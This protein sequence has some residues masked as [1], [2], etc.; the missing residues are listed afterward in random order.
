M[1]A[2]SP[3][4]LQRGRPLRV[5]PVC[6]STCV[7]VCVPGPELGASLWLSEPSSWTA[8]ADR[9]EARLLG[10]LNHCNGC[11][12]QKAFILKRLHTSIISPISI[13][14]S[15]LNGEWQD[16]TLVPSHVRLPDRMPCDFI[17]VSL[18]PF[19]ARHRI[20]NH[21]PFI[22]SALEYWPEQCLTMAVNPFLAL[23]TCLFL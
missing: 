19:F 9:Q 15:R 11:A 21:L 14:T 2:A 8:W 22:F 12:V 17:C 13:R 1:P 3:P 4:P 10:C 6:R 7:C 20:F 16:F 18:F 23:E 5:C